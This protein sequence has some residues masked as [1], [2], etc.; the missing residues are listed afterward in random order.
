MFKAPARFYRIMPS[1]IA[2]YFDYAASTPPFK[3]A[4]RDYINASL[5]S[6]ANPSSVHTFGISA[7]KVAAMTFLYF[8]SKVSAMTFSISAQKVSAMT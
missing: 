4:L 1:P 7:Q 5:Q 2:H 6:F 8:C 3:D